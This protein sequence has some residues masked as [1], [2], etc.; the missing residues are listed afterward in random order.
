MEDVKDL[1]VVLKICESG[2]KEGRGAM[3]RDNATGKWRPGGQQRTLE[4]LAT[5]PP[6]FHFFL[7]ESCDYLPYS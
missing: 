5:V 6:T 2:R 3:W 7:R 1:K 4:Q